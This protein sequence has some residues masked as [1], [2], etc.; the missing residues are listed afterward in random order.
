MRQSESK[1]ERSILD[2]DSLSATTIIKPNTTTNLTGLVGKHKDEK[3]SLRKI[4]HHR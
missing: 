1:D 2:M 3:R 4:F